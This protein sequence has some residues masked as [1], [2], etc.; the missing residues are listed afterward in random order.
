MKGRLAS[1]PQRETLFHAGRHV[2]VRG[3]TAVARTANARVLGW[4]RGRLS[5]GS[6]IVGSR[7]TI[8]TPRPSTLLD[9]KRL[10]IQ[11]L[12]ALAVVAVIVNH[13]AG[14]PDGGFIGVDVFFVISGFLITGIL[15][16]ER[17]ASGQISLR[18]FY[19]RRIKRLLPAAVVV[20]A[21]T[22][23]FACILLPLTRAFDIVV[24][25]VWG[26]LFAANW[27]FILLG[28]DYMHASD[29]LSP[30]QH[31]WS[32]SVEEQF[33]LI[34]PTVIILV[35]ALSRRNPRRTVVISMALI[36]I[37]SF[38]WSIWETSANPTWAYFSTFSRAWELGLGALLACAAPRFSRLTSHARTAAGWVGFTILILGSF[39]IS[40]ELAF[41]GPWALVPVFGTLLVIAAG[42]GTAKS[43]IF[44]LTNPISTYIGTISYSLYLWH[45]PVIVFVGTV[46]P[47]RG[48][49]YLVLSLAL[50][51]ALSVLT[52]HWVEDPLRKK[53]WAIS[54]PKITRASSWRRNSALVALVAAVCILGFMTAGSRVT[55]AAAGI[56]VAP[57]LEE[58]SSATPAQQLRA[59]DI[60]R[61]LASQEWPDLA[62][63][64]SELGP[65][66]R[67][68]EWVEDGCLGL[69]SNNS[70]SPE[71]NAK[72][73][74]YGEPDAAKT[75]AVL[76]DSQ[77]ISYMPAIREAIGRD[78]AIQ[79]YAMSQCPAVD[80]S[81][82]FGDGAAAPNCDAF[83]R[84][85]FEEIKKTSPDLV[86]VVSAPGAATRLADG[87]TGRAAE[88]EWEAGISR[89]FESLIDQ[90]VVSLDTP[91]TMKSLHD[92]AITGSKPLDCVSAPSQEF[93]DLGASVRR[94]AAEFPN[95]TVPETITWFCSSDGE[96]P[97]FIDGV[98]TL[99][100]GG[101]LSNSASRALSPLMRLALGFKE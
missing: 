63:A 83:R 84:W 4:K 78:W 25:A 88:V 55:E 46:L 71:D 51:V 40:D 50:I 24:D 58:T 94:I 47:Q 65:D 93:I 85:A 101:H 10:D 2:M 9:G 36:T 43:S 54:A 5:L 96:C 28:T 66:S 77:S 7:R 13:L 62:P 48:E 27:R 20:M 87:L 17:S 8:S 15:L 70:L 60:D 42:I 21:T 52:Y 56:S 57:L 99:V 72:R 64:L 1:A 32:L 6:R 69:E 3:V 33:Y 97:S 49:K 14:W 30:I 81:V 31:F 61:A 41:P 22:L 75:I 12:R 26:F 98:P 38:A 59:A 29:S 95:V 16:R 90:K 39:L 86:V 67:V 37:A 11:G 45:L 19:I 53:R 89:T 76:G 73:C 91:P 18:K 34:W 44:P 82:L 92:C 35:F 100:D 79:I 74:I 23:I 68:S 80:V